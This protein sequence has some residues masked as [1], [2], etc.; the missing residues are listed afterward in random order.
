MLEIL[1]FLLFVVLAAALFWFII[2]IFEKVGMPIPQRVLQLLGVAF[3]IVVVI[4]LLP[5]L[6][7]L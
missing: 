7:L 2:F 6:G 4:K 5:M 1:H 3:L